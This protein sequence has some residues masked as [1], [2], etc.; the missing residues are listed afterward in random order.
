M[1]KNQKLSRLF[2]KFFGNTSMCILGEKLFK[3]N[4]T[5]FEVKYPENALPRLT[6]QKK[7]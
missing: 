7:W 2:E 6:L 1:N 3:N 4:F 5:V